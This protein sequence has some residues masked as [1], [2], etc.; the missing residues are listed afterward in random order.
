MFSHLKYFVFE[1]LHHSPK[2]KTGESIPKAVEFGY[3]PGDPGIFPVKP[4][5]CQNHV[6]AV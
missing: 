6:C 1:R 4:E 2:L 5:P 3:D